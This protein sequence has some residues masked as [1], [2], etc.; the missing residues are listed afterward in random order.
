MRCRSG[1]VC[2]GVVEL[3]SDEG[4]IVQKLFW[5]CGGRSGFV[6]VRVV[7]LWSVE[8]GIVQELFWLCGCGLVSSVGVLH[9]MH[10]LIGRCG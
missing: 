8:G 10:G 2:V 9:R 1:F 4:G 3:W 6:Y 5:L 7:E